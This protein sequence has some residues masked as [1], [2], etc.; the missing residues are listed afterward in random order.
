MCTYFTDILILLY[1]PGCV[2]RTQCAIADG[3]CQFG[4]ADNPSS[5]GRFANKWIGIFNSSEFPCSGAILNVTMAMEITGKEE[6]GIELQIWKII[7]NTYLLVNW[8]TPEILDCPGCVKTPLALRKPL[9]FEKGDVLGI[10]LNNNRIQ[11]KYSTSD[12]GF[13]HTLRPLRSEVLILATFDVNRIHNAAGL[14][15]TLEDLNTYSPASSQAIR[16]AQAYPLIEMEL[17][18]KT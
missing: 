1:T 4:N 10:S 3:S 11:L 15:L 2:N 6:R 17:E 9:P 18:G 14:A 16:F 5:S 13:D 7:N 12:S 8:T